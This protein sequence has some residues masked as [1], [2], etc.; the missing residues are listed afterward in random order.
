[1]GIDVWVPRRAAPAAATPVPTAVPAQAAIAVPAAA[2]AARATRPAPAVRPAAAEPASAV[3]PTAQ[4][5]PSRSPQA[6]AGTAPPVP[7]TTWD[8]LKAEVLACTRCPLH[9]TRTQGVFGVGSREAQWLVVGE[10]PGAEE[11]RRGEPFVGRAGHL[12]DAMLRSIG[13]SRGTNVYIANVLKSRP[14]GNRDPKPEEVTA[15]LPYLMRQIELLRPRLMLA[16]GRIAAQNLLATDVPLGRLRGK[17]HH[18][19]ELNTPLIVTY[20]PAYLLR[21]PADKRKAWED[22]K[23]AR[24]VFRELQPT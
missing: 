16:V 4:V 22:L 7:G 8:S 10:A 11:D 19:G 12:L 24:S 9:T 13:L 6:A 1:M 2:I 14:P 18:F 5:H 17:V 23:F 20:H 15:C 3:T 21:T